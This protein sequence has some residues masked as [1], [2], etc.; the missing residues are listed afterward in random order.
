[1]KSTWHELASTNSIQI[2]PLF[3]LYDTDLVTGLPT[4]E[5]GHASASSFGIPTVGQAFVSLDL[6]AFAI[7]VQCRQS[8]AFGVHSSGSELYVLPANLNDNQNPY[9]RGT[10]CV[11]R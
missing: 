7:P 5:L 4:A 11:A 10:T 3:S 6:T 8:L 1:M 9:T 2:K